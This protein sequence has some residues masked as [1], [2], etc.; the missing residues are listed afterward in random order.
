MTAKKASQADK[1]KDFQSKHYILCTAVKGD[2]LLFVKIRIIK[3]VK[4][5]KAYNFNLIQVMKI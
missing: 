1:F 5:W 3:G 2:R 4:N